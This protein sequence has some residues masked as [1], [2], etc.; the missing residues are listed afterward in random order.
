MLGSINMTAGSG[1]A[2]NANINFSSTVIQCLVTGKY[3]VEFLAENNSGLFSNLSTSDFTVVN[4]ANVPP[5]VSGLHAP[6][7]IQVPVSGTNTAVLSILA[8]DPDGNCDIKNV[9]FNSYRPDGTITG[10]SP[11]TM[12]DDGNIPVHG[13][14]VAGDGRYSLIIGIPSSQTTFGYFKFQYQAR[15]YSNLLSNQLIDSINVYP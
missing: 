9:F 15:D 3:S 8:N 13:D 4:T 7:S 5:V 11:F 12:Y 6:A 1:T 10:G 14:T 2:Y